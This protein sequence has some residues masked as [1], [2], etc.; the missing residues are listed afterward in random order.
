MKTQKKKLILVISFLVIIVLFVVAAIL[1]YE[2]SR[3]TQAVFGTEDISLSSLAQ[4][5]TSP[6]VPVSI[7]I[8]TPTAAPTSTPAPVPESTLNDIPTVPNK[9]LSF[10]ANGPQTKIFN[11]SIS[12]A[13]FNPSLIVVNEGDSVEL[14]LKAVDGVYDF[15]FS[16]LNADSGQIQKDESSLMSFLAQTSG[17]YV[18]ECRTYCPYGNRIAGKVVVLPK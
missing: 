13:G 9:I 10:S 7:P 15:Y 2:K 3:G 18:F 16:N 1:L 5:S 11:V 17:Q 14:S 8:S 4:S 12:K 6:Y